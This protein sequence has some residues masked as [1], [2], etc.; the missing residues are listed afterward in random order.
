M[1]IYTNTFRCQ[2]RANRPHCVLCII[3]LTI[4]F[5][6]LT[7]LPTHIHFTQ[8]PAN[9]VAELNLLCC[10]FFCRPGACIRPSLSQTHFHPILIPIPIPIPIQF[11]CGPSC[12]KRFA[13]TARGDLKICSAKND[14]VINVCP[15][16]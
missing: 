1:Y 3:I 7:Q 16:I 4:Y 14:A 5:V 11:L 6:Q 12:W 9:S 13:Q 10:R 8:L 2:E 15:Y